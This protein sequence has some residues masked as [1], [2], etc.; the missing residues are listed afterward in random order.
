MSNT[1]ER[2]Y[3]IRGILILSV[4]AVIL[5]LGIIATI[6][7]VSSTNSE[8]EQ[9]AGEEQQD[10]KD[11]LISILTTT[12]SL[13]T[14]QVQASLNT[15]VEKTTQLGAPRLQSGSNPPVLY[16]GNTPMNGNTQI[17][18]SVTQ[19]LGGTATLFVRQG[20]DYVRVAT[21]VIKD[22]KRATGTRLDPN[23]LAIASIRNKDTFIGQVDIL[24][25]PYIT[26]YKPILDATNT[27]IGI[28]YVGYNADIAG[29]KDTVQS[30]RVLNDGIV[31]LRDDKGR[32]RAHSDNLT[33]N[34]LSRI[35]LD[36]SSHWQ[37]QTYP[38]TPWRYTIDVAYSEDEVNSIVAG[39][40]SRLVIML[41][42][43]ALVLIAILVVLVRKSVSAPLKKLS[44]RIHALASAEGDL[45][46]RFERGN[47]REVNEISLE[48]N[49]LLEKL[50][51]TIAQSSDASHSI[52]TSCEQLTA[53]AAQS[54]DVAERQA[55]ETE[56]VATAIN[57]LNATAHSV[58]QS[59]A[60][61]E[62]M[63]VDIADLAAATRELV[64]KTTS[65]AEQQRR[66]LTDTSLRSKELTVLSGNID[67]VLS[68]IE[69][70]AEQTNLLALNA[71]IESARAGEHGRGF[72]V[73]SDEV[74]QLAVRTQESIKEI[75]SNIAK[76]QQ[77]VEQV[78]DSVLECAQQSEEVATQ[79]AE[80]ASGITSLTEKI[81][82]IRSTNVEM[83]SVAEE[84]SQVTEQLSMNVETIRES[85]QQNAQFVESTNTSA[86]RVAE[87]AEAINEQLRGYKTR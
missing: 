2:Q 17:V 22:G 81:D 12:N 49:A 6:Y 76:V 40:L 63:S 35:N 72:A 15:L 30:S 51:N 28:W 5:L 19:L 1:A 16:F 46:Q 45:T 27:V 64:T 54:H 38:F 43:G 86:H 71:A 57:E 66:A 42:I 21:N 26:A 18:D 82:K 85:S 61:A 20:N 44:N 13:M 68:V 31:V 32:V 23:G 8:I 39:E 83:A 53:T 29:L 4:S 14:Q 87:L 34:E 74:R 41:L 7:L 80:T 3:S 62:T 9:R 47:I 78:D 25:K 10:I 65:L 37:N 77:A 79:S 24:G 58:A 52:A 59:A 67:N 55:E 48:F 75:Q 36:D 11:E 84:Q 73:V 56:Q 33:D 60:E 50:R 69:S 70:I